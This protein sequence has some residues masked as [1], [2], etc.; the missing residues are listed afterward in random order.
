MEQA[1]AVRPSTRD[2]GGLAPRHHCRPGKADAHPSTAAPR[3]ASRPGDA[4]RRRARP[5]ER[6]LRACRAVSASPSIASISSGLASPRPRPSWAAPRGPSNRP[7]ATLVT[8]FATSWRAIMDPLDQRLTDAGTAWRQSQPEPPDLDR[9]VARAR[10]SNV[11]RLLAETRVRRRGRAR[12]AQRPCR[13]WRRRR[14]QRVPKRYCGH[15][16]HQPRADQEPRADFDL[17]AEDCASS[18]RRRRRK[19]RSPAEPTSQP[20]E[21]KQAAI[22]LDSYERALVAGEWQTAFDM[23]SPSSPTRKAG[24]SGYAAEREPYFK[25]V[26]GRYTVGA[27]TQPA[28]LDD[29]RAA[30]RR[31]RYVPRVSDRS[32]LSRLERQQRRVR[33]VRRR[34]RCRRKVVDLARPVADARCD[35][36]LPDRGMGHVAFNMTPRRRQPCRSS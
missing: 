27:P 33:A 16:D 10:S 20:N 34:T 30:H 17:C 9:L 31:R 19:R 7:S 14:L 18:D 6:R 5:R 32:R 23:L 22:L 29:V 24:I 36:P 12:S 28:R 26:A 15:A 4:D 13:G 11:A 8:D 25:S 21:G 2:A 1:L 35:I 3:D